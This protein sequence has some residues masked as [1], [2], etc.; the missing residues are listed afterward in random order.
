MEDITKSDM[1]GKINATPIIEI[2]KMYDFFP[3][4]ENNQEL[5]YATC[6]QVREAQL[7]AAQLQNIL[8]GIEK[9]S[10]D[11]QI[12]GALAAENLFASALYST[13][14]PDGVLSVY[15]SEQE[16]PTLQNIEAGTSITI[17]NKEDALSVT[18]K[19]FSTHRNMYG[20][21]IGKYQ[22]SS[23]SVLSSE[24]QETITIPYDSIHPEK[25]FKGICTIT[26][27]VDGK[28]VPFAQKFEIAY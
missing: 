7:L 16:E 15:Y 6:R 17:E 14:F 21:E 19:N 13:C 22:N 2:L 25:P 4:L 20:I 11:M 24:Q 5:F 23:V 1:L 10:T 26:A 27:Y 8:I 28:E 3:K 9:E 18:F 12:A